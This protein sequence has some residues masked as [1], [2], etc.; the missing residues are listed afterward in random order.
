MG[1]HTKKEVSQNAFQKVEVYS[2]IEV[3]VLET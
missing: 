3:R 1:S 2:A